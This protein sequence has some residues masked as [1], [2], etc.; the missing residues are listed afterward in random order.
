MQ[1][2]WPVLVGA[3]VTAIVGNFLVQRWQLRNWKE[4]QRQLGDQVA[5]DE[6]KKLV[7]EISIKSA[8]RHTAMRNLVSSLA[9]DSRIDFKGAL[10][11]YRNQ[12]SIWNG[13]LNSF[14]VRIRHNLNYGWAIRLEHEMHD[15]FRI[16]GTEIEKVI[17]SRKAGSLPDWQSLE[18]PKELLNEIQASSYN[19]QRDLFTKFN[20]RKLEIFEGRRLYYR[21]GALREYS[22]LDLIKAIFVVSVDEYY[23]IRT[24]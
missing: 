22:F 4:Q 5:L 19:F 14:Y 17:R 20:S 13:S 18:V 6:F 7:E 2:I 16:A 9:P 12:L 3:L 24:P 10:E 11:D 1:A 21:E 15:K 8:D 23:I